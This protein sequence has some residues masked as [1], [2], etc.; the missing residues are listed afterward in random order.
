MTKHRFSLLFAALI[1]LCLCAADAYA[2]TVRIGV[3][4]PVSGG[5]AE[6]GERMKM[7]ADLAI[8]ER[9][10]KVGDVDVEFIFRDTGDASLQRV[11]QLA[12]ELVVRD[13]VDYLCGLDTTPA[14]LAV[15]DV[16]N[17]AKIP[18]VI[19]NSGTSGVT[20]KSPYF[21]RAG[22]TQWTVSYPF[23]K[24]LGEGGKKRLAIVIADFAPGYD[25]AASFT[26]GFTE[27]GGTIVETLKVPL[28]TSDPS[29]YLQ[30]IQDIAP[31]GVFMF[32]NAGAF[33]VNFVRD[34]V[35]KGL[36]EKGIELYGTGELE[37]TSLKSIGRGAI[38]VETAF[39]YGLDLKNAKNTEFVGHLRAKHGQDFLPHPFHVQAYDGMQII[40]HMIEKTKGESGGDAAINAAKG[41]SW[42]SP[43]GSVSIDPE[44]REIVQKVYLRK[45]VDDKGLL[46]NREI[47]DLG[48]IRPP[49]N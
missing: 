26:A 46:V 39:V 29:S 15:A 5:A 19:F 36:R 8:E 31:D 48:E 30:K 17:Q 27:A 32:F 47:G 12:Q 11:R 25:A 20:K 18:F 41:F 33:S 38:G 49:A 14:V 4:I 16:V 37:E 35:A 3:L 1:S 44:T 28:G 22:F 6:Y 21:I 24:R 45:V 34:Y 23:G 40:F 10:G 13:R 43:R 2:R 7:G 9:K 42:S